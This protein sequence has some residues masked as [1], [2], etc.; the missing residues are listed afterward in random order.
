MILESMIQIA[1]LIFMGA[2]AFTDDISKVL[3]FGFIL[4]ASTIRS[5]CKNHSEGE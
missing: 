1:A 5:G 3:F 2:F 4:I